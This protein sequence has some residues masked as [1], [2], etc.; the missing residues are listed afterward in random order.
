M[1]YIL[2]ALGFLGIGIGVGWFWQKHTYEQMQPK[3]KEEFCSQTASNGFLSSYIGQ[4]VGRLCLST[5]TPANLEKYAIPALKTRTPQGSDL[6]LGE[7]ISKVEENVKL[8]QQGYG[9][10]KFSFK[11]EGKLATGLAHIPLTCTEQTKC[12]VILQSR[13]FIAQEDFVP[14]AG[15]SPSAREFAKAG[16]IS[17]A[18]DFLGYGGSDMPSQNVFEERFQKYTTDLDL[19]SIVGQLPMADAS[20]IGL[21]GHSNGGQVTLTILEASGKPYPTVLWA[22]VSAPFPYSILVYSDDTADFGK[23]QR[24]DLATF[25][26][27]YNVDDYTVVNFYDLIQGPIQLHQGTADDLVPTRWSQTMVRNLKAKKKAITYFEYPGAD[28]NLRPDWD[29]AVERSIEFF[30]QHLGT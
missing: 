20:R 12:P 24:K 25:E 7:Q 29:T 13:G 4:K 22:P 15:T 23:A 27:D 26:D 2:I 16:F 9:V 30:T 14:G 3:T 28:H 21:W 19:L 18:P 8:K 6:K 5:R 17:L 11:T 1:K 10:Y